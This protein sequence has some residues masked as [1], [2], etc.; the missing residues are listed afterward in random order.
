MF[1]T[2]QYL[3]LLKNKTQIQYNTFLHSFLNA[4]DSTIDQIVLIDFSTF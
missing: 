4:I 1:Q 3:R 2:Q